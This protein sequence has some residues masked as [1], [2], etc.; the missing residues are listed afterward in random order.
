[1]P[2]ALTLRIE[3]FHP[4][5]HDGICYGRG[6][7]ELDAPLAKLFLTYKDPINRK[8]TA[9]LAELTGPQPRI[10]AKVPE[11]QAFGQTFLEQ[12]K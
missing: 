8:P 4:I 1:M 5:T 6:C 11:A 12:L 7:H 10:G 2:E 9:R 3:L